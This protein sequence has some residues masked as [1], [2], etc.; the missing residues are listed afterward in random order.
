MVGRTEAV[1]LP[2]CSR[3]G[4]SRDGLESR[5]RARIMHA[6]EGGARRTG[7]RCCR[8]L[9]QSEL[10]DEVAESVV[11]IDADLSERGGVFGDAS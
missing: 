8:L 3:R 2:P 11:K 4:G 5:E 9:A 7:P 1:A 10:R 6:R